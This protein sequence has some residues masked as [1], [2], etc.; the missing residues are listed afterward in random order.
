MAIYNI[1]IM[2][3]DATDSRPKHLNLSGWFLGLLG[4]LVVGLPVGGFALSVLYFAP[5]WLQTNIADME[6]KVQEAKES[7]RP[8]QEQNADLAAKKQQLEQQLQQEREARAQA[9]T[10]ITM[11]R[12]ARS[13]SSNRLAELEGEVISLKKSLASYEKLLKPKLQRE[14][15]QCVDLNATVTANNS[16]EYKT[17]FTKVSKT[18]SLPGN[19]TVKVRVLA[20]DN[21]MAMQQ[22][23]TTATHTLDMS[24]SSNVKGMIALPSASQTGGSTRMLDMKV[25]DGS[26]PVG[27]CWKSF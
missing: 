22:G 10:E 26:T 24:K 12:T 6:K 20:G 8:L 16:V 11:S 2:R 15:V 5:N 17:T 1:M 21:A 14:L 19:L 4:L 18:A 23:T 7:L 13:E 25:F 27:Y 3:R 9:D